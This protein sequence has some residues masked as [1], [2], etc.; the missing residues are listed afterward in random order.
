[1][2]SFFLKEFAGNPDHADKTDEFRDWA[3]DVGE[4]IFLSVTMLLQFWRVGSAYGWNA[5]SSTRWRCG[6]AA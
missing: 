3:S 4:G 1:M 2:A 6:F 5:L